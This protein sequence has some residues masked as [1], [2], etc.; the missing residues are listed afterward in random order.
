[1]SLAELVI[2]SVTVEGRSRDYNISRRVKGRRPVPA[3]SHGGHQGLGRGVD[4]EQVAVIGVAVI[5]VGLAVG[6]QQQSRAV[7]W[8]KRHRMC[9]LVRES[10]SRTGILI[11]ASTLWM[12]VSSTVAPKP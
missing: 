9:S 11:R 1:M 8:P 12:L 6:A 2:V 3:S 4:D 5:G 7:R 10:L